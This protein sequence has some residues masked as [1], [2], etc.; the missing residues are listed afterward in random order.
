[1]RLADRIGADA[2]TI[3]KIAEE[4][5]V[6]PMTI[7]LHVPNKEAIIDDMVDDVFTEI[8][9]PPEDMD[10][11]DAI[12]LRSRSMRSVL[13]THPWAAPLMESRT[14]PGPAT[15]ALSRPDRVHPRIR[16]RNLAIN[17]A[18]RSTSAST[19]SLTG[20]NMQPRQ[21]LGST[22]HLQSGSLGRRV[23]FGDDLIQLADSAADVVEPVTDL[24]IDLVENRGEQDRVSGART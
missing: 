17:M 7:Y 15:L 24:A 19:S 9:L 12:L 10:W 4:I 22:L 18:T 20:S 8:A 13:A 2:L 5:D 14:S 11:S 21:K 3:G 6:K 23:E 1:M 16:H